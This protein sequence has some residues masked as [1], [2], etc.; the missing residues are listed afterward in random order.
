MFLTSRSIPGAATPNVVPPASRGTPNSV[1]EEVDLGGT[2]TDTDTIVSTVHAVDQKDGPQADT[3]PD[4][5]VAETVVTAVDGVLTDAGTSGSSNV[6]RR[7]LEARTPSA[8]PEFRKKRAISDYNQV[9]EGTG[10]ALTDRDAS[11]QG[12]AYLTFRVVDNSTYNVRDCLDF[13]SS[14]SKCGTWCLIST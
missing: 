6:R 8:T 4:L 11:I 2:L 7:T 9:F 14:E 5:P 12:T 13:C 1:T 3:P 10:T